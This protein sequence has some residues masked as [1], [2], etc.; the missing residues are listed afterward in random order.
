M[1][2]FGLLTAIVDGLQWIVRQ[3]RIELI[4]HFLDN[5]ALMGGPY[6]GSCQLGPDTL[7]STCV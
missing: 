4:E 3:K 7:I 5:F 2:P 6:D 1:L